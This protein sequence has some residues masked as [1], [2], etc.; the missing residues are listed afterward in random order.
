MKFFM[1][2]GW[3]KEQAAGIVGNLQQE[4]GPNLK[5]NLPGDNG[6]AYG[7]AQWHPDRQ[8]IF[9][10][11]YGKSIRDSTFPEQLA[12][13]DY[14]LNH[15]ESSAGRMLRNSSTAGEAADI[16]DSFYERSR[17]TEKGIRI[18]N[19]LALVKEM[20]DASTRLAASPTSGQVA[21]KNITAATN[22]S[23]A[24][25]TGGTPSDS[26][27]KSTPQP[28]GRGHEYAQQV[29]VNKATP[30]KQSTPV[31]QMSIVA[32]NPDTSMMLHVAGIHDNPIAQLST[33]SR[34]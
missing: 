20:G 10:S 8:K 1:S 11:V 22:K 14:E 26:Q 4:S 5:I 13:V 27:T 12:F 34:A 24:E 17:G 16:V 29:V 19:A 7:I 18:A 28:S 9:E 6:Q 31:P 30:A 25:H 3:T 15:N 21:E 33:I 23:P 32:R 2:K